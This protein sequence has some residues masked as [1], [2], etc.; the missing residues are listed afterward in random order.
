M[1]SNLIS[2]ARQAN[3]GSQACNM[4]STTDAQHIV[5]VLKKNVLLVADLV[6]ALQIADGPV[7]PSQSSPPS[8]TTVA[9][10]NGSLT[11]SAV[12]GLDVGQQSHIN[13]SSSYSSSSTSLDPNAMLDTSDLS[14]KR[15]ASSVAGDRVL[16][17]MKLEPQD[18]IPPLHM[19]SSTGMHLSGPPQSSTGFSVTS[20]M[21]TLPTSV[22]TMHD[23]SSLPPVLPAPASNS[24]PPSSAGIPAHHQLGLSTEAQQSSH[25]LHSALHY[26][27]MDHGHPL[28]PPPAEYTSAPAQMPP[29]A[30]PSTNFNPSLSW[31]GH[32]SVTRHHQHSLSAGSVLVGIPESNMTAGPSSLQ[33]PPAYNSPT[34]ATQVQQLPPSAASSSVHAPGVHSVRSSRSSSFAHPSGEARPFVNAYD[35]MPRR[36]STSGMPSRASSPDYEDDMDTGHD[37]DDNDSGEPSPEYYHSS[38]GGGATDANEMRSNGEAIGADGSQNHVGQRR[39]SRGSPSAEGGS[40]GHGNEVPQEYRAEVERIFFEFLNNICSKRK[41]PPSRLSLDRHD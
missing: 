34:R 19:Q 9:T 4:G 2:I 23:L 14:R 29:S 22:S 21:T 16:K 11:V 17:A 38:P 25:S 39:M 3:S 7:L 24:R 18:D 15:C 31:D 26:P 6:A 36:S 8:H 33:Y 37:S 28:M 30:L 5:D 41:L 40:T 35:L 12:A 13:G 20:S 10:D 1:V 32:V 27:P